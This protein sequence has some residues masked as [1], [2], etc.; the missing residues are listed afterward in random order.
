L[1]ARAAR[2]GPP[3]DPPLWVLAALGAAL[4]PFAVELLSYY[5]AF[6]IALAPLWE[7]RAEIGRW[8]LGL[9]AFTQFVAWAPLRDMSTWMD[10]QYTLMSVGMLL[11]FAAILWRFSRAQ[12][13]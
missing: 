5:Y 1:L 9:T 6:I 12:P 8:L 10:E 13:A 11:V 3:D 4:I 2:P 7:R